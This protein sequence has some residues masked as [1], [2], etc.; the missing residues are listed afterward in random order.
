[1]RDV[2]SILFVIP[3]RNNDSALSM[4]FAKRLAKSIA[5]QGSF[6]D[7]FVVGKTLNPFEFI[8]QGVK[9]RSRVKS[10]GA[11]VVVAQYGTFTGFLV[12]LFAPRPRIVTFRGTDLNPAPTENGLYVFFQHLASHVAS[13]LVDGIICVSQELRERL[14][15][16]KQDIAIIPSSTDTELFR[17][18]TQAECRYRLGWA[19]DK[20]IALFFAGSN[21]RVKRL[22][23]AVEIEKLLWSRDTSIELKIVREAISQHDMP[24][25]LNSADCLVLLSNFEGSPNLVR[26]ACACNTPVVTVRVGDVCEVLRD[27]VP[28]QIVER[29]INELT[30]AV[31]RMTALRKRSNGRDHVQ[32]FSNEITARRTIKFYSRI[33]AKYSQKYV[34]GATQP[35]CK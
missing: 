35:L 18:L 5:A 22:D 9:L 3:G 16:R 14:Y 11:D 21:S 6:V 33:I 12:A 32:Q 13:F 30:E 29:D 8:K 25:Y 19:I 15:C 26:E 4:S 28:S 7:T 34:V 23:I 24:I 1:V 27:V 17:P 20:P 2:R 10:V 31:C